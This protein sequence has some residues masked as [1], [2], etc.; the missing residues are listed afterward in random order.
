G[1][2]VIDYVAFGQEPSTIP[3][4]NI[5]QDHFENDSSINAFTYLGVGYSASVNPDSS[6]VTISGDGSTPQFDPLTYIFRNSNLDTIDIDVSGNNK[7]YVKVKSSVPNTA[8]RMDLQ[9]IDGFVTTQG[10]IT[11]IVGTEY[12][13]LE[14]DFTGTFADL[15]FGGTPCTQ[16]TAPCPVNATRIADILIFIEPGVGMFLGDL[17]IDYISF[18]VPLEP[19]GPEAVLAYE[20]HFNNEMLEFTGDPGGLVSTET[21][22][23]WIITG[24]GSSGAFSAV[25]Y[26]FHDKNTG[27]QI[28][29]DMGP[30]LDK[31][32]LKARVDSMT[33]SVPLRLDILDT[34]GYVSSTA[35]I[36]KI[37]DAQYQEYEFNFAGN[38]FDGGFGGSPCTAGPCPIDP[39]AITQILVYPDPAQGAFNG[40]IYID[41][42]SVGKPAGPD[43][44]PKGIIN[45][46]DE[47]DDNTSLFTSDMTGLV[48][49]FANDEWTITGDGSSGAFSPVVYG[50]HNDL[51]ELIMA[52]A[53]GSNDKLFIKAKSSVDSTVLRVDL[54]DN[55]GFVSNLNPPT[56]TLSTEYV[57][58]E[59]DYAGAYQDGGFGGSPCATGPCPVDGE[60]V[61]NLQ[62][63]INPGVGAFNGSITIDWLS[64]GASLTGLENPTILNRF[65]AFPNPVEDQLQLEYDLLKPTDVK[66]QVFDAM[67]RMVYAQNEGLKASGNQAAQLDLQRLSPGVYVVQ[68]STTQERAGTMRIIKQ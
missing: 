30:S 29:L 62:F 47:M 10:S 18:G 60:R 54:Q 61:E 8:L 43:A 23:D 39:T 7:M 13:V 41:Y 48:S 20:D 64:F 19:A 24:D 51:G 27:G 3:T 59:L 14:Y 32:F 46:A 34:A 1:T 65:Q 44:G 57:I 31:V 50:L 2:I 35:A 11:K 52:D 9:D 67:G 15:G 22:S 45:Y 5:F 58:Y 26:I 36:T 33:A 21:G 28:F 38:Y 53:I 63:F 25:S 12:T 55:E 37:I 66:I 56:A 4:S 49:S 42:V 40:T 68:L 16:Q 6:T 17:T